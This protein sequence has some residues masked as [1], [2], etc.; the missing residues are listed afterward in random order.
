MRSLQLTRAAGE[1]SQR[2]LDT[3]AGYGRLKPTAGHPEAPVGRGGRCGAV[4]IAQDAVR[5]HA[6]LPA[7]L[8]PMPMP[9]PMPG[10]EASLR[11]P[12]PQA[13]SREV[14][15][16]PPAVDHGAGDDAERS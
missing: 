1:A 7:K 4:R 9:M 2:V 13:L 14:G 8:A 12:L 10:L 11:A 3:M 15:S 16:A 5:A 6:A